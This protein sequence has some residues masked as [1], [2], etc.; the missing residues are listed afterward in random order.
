MQMRDGFTGV[1]AIVDD[2]PIAAVFQAQFRG[3]LPSLEHQIAQD[4]FIL[5]TRVGNAGDMFLWDNEHMRGRVRLDVAKGQHEVVFID[6]VR[7]N[8]AGDDFFEQGHGTI[9][10]E[11]LKM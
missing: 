1:R 10:R 7:G 11:K 2:E 5:W 8:L 9:K 3:D 6:N 4:F